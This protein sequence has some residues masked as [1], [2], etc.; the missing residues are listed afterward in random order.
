MHRDAGASTRAEHSLIGIEDR[1]GWED[2][3]SGVPHAFAHTWTYSRAIQR[4]SGLATSLY[5]GLVD[6][7]RVLCPIAER[8]HAGRVDIVTPPGFSG[9][10]GTGGAERFPDAWH[11][12]A[13]SRGWVCGFITLNPFLP[14]E[15]Y[16]RPAEVYAYNELFSIDLRTSDDERF[17][18]LSVNRR[19]QLRDWQ[20]LSDTLVHDRSRLID[21][22]VGHHS[23]FLQDR[24][25]S[26]ASFFS[27]DA[28][29]ELLED[30]RVTLVGAGERTRLEAVT[31]FAHT[32]AVGDY[33]FNVSLSEGR[34]HSAKLIWYGVRHL[35]ALGVPVLNLG[36]GIRAGDGVADFKR[37]FGAA[38]HP[39]RSLRQVYDAER[40]ESLCRAAG[41][42]P[43]DRGGFFP[44]YG[45][46]AR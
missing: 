9:F 32:A 35:A 25:A 45:A 18:R 5:R 4:T 23:G 26:S 34:G 21:F 42:D 15:S 44:P 6:G 33:L 7:V 3:L 17:E 13:R 12:F 16:F 27:A 19:R 22:L 40:Y 29:R 43:A 11:E 20:R 10:V 38:T 30:E 24:G 2:A 14:Q 41:V 8:E 28:L 46:P 39:L 37:R 1:R 31:A 36:G